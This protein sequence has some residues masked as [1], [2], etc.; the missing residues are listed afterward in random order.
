MTPRARSR[1]RTWFRTVSVLTCSSWAICFVEL[2]PLEMTQHLGLTGRQVRGRCA[3]LVVERAGQQAEDADHTLATHQRHRAHLQREA[4]SVGRDEH[5]A[6][7]GRRGRAEHLAGEELLRRRPVLRADNRGE[8]PAA[9]VAEEAL[10]R[11]V[12]PPD[13]SGRVEDVA[14]DGQAGERPLDVTADRQ[15]ACR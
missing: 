2:S 12:D 11:R 10:S 14:R 6:G 9:N 3:G 4:G 15:P 1:W 8:V 5:P 7:L 13:D